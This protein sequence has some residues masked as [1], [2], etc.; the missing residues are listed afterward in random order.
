MQYIRTSTLCKNMNFLH[1]SKCPISPCF[2]PGK[3]IALYK[4]NHI[5]CRYTCA[6]KSLLIDNSCISLDKVNL[7]NNIPKIKKSVKT[8][9]C[10]S[11][12]A[13]GRPQT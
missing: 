7:H 5:I 10:N 2:S 4:I 9:L 6:T 3:Y 11:D 13:I 8:R 12:G 1:N